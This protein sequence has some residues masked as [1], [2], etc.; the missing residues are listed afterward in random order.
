[1]TCNLC[2]KDGH[3]ARN[4]TLG[5]KH[6]SALPVQAPPKPTGPRFASEKEEKDYQAFRRA[7]GL[8][9]AACATSVQVKPEQTL[10]VTEGE[11]IVVEAIAQAVAESQKSFSA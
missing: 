2:G 4:C 5:R 11:M 10:P 7:M 1:M 8:N 3:L 6:A 9:Q